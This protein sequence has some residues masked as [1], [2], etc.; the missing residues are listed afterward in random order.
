MYIFSSLSDDFTMACYITL[1]CKQLPFKG[2]SFF[3]LQLHVG[4]ICSGGLLIA[5]LLCFF[6]ICVM[7]SVATVANFYSVFVEYFVESA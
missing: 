1:F 7:F 6:I 2:H 4:L 3:I 5:F